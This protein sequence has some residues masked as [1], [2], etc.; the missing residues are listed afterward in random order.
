MKFKQLIKLY[1]SE[2]AGPPYTRRTR[3]GETIYYKDPEH[4]I[5]HRTEKDPRTG[6]T[7]PAYIKDSGTKWWMVDN[8]L[9]RDEKN[10]RT[11]LSLPAVE[12]SDGIK[13]WYKNNTQH[14]LDG[15]AVE[16]SNGTE[17]WYINGIEL[18]P[19]EIEEQ[20]QKIALNN[21]V[22]SDTGNAIGGLFDELH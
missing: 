17:L 20:K 1:E 3:Y 5:M 13:S 15:P 22:K 19:K 11:G 12:T 10:P 16:L 9:H 21:R 7:L 18:S 6:L 14:R 4:K 2:Q 8:K